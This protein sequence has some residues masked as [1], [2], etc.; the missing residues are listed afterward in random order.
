MA[1]NTLSQICNPTVDITGKQVYLTDKPKIV[2]PLAQKFTKIALVS[3]KNSMNIFE[4]IGGLSKPEQQFLTEMSKQFTWK[5][6]L[7]SLDFSTLTKSQKSNK[8]RTYNK[9]RQ[10]D[11]VKRIDKNIY[12]MNPR[13]LIPSD[14]AKEVEAKH[15]WDSIP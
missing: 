10:K 4:I 14:D 1:N 11:L 2:N 12:L 5:E 15:L 3:G 9:L 13:L 7:I 8:Y 6:Y